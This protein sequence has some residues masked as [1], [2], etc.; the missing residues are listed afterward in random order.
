MKLK[1]VNILLLVVAAGIIVYAFFY[2]KNFTK[3]KPIRYLG[4]FGEKSYEAKGGKTDTVYHT[5]PG[6]SFTN[7]DGKTI[8][9]KDYNGSIYVADFF[10]TTCHSICPIMSDQMERVYAK[11]K[12]NN[13][14]KFLSHTVDP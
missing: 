3:D 6:F 12:G 10:F 8:T 14:V 1:F 5:I 11:F 7:Q 9:D 4:I 2:N 13:E